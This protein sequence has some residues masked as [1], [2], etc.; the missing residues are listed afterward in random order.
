M[1][2][3]W[4]L[5]ILQRIYRSSALFDWRTRRRHRP[6]PGQWIIRDPWRGKAVE[7]QPLV[8]GKD[9]WEV[10][11]DDWHRF[12]WLRDMRE[13]GGSQARTMSRRVVLEWVER[14][15][16]W[17]ASTW[18]PHVT[19]DRLKNLTLLWGWFGESASL[20]Q[21]HALLTSM[22]VQR[23]CLEKDWAS[24]ATGDE[25]L[26]ALSGLIPATLFLHPGAD[27]SAAAAA[28][29]KE[30]SDLILGDGCHVS[31]RP[32]MHLDLLKALIE[33]R[34]AMAAGRSAG[35]APSPQVDN[36]TSLI[37]D[38]IVRMGSVGRMWRH[39]DGT[40]MG[41]LG[42]SGVDPELAG[43]VLA[44]AGPEGKVTRHAADGGFIRITS[45][46]SVMMMNACPPSF[47]ASKTAEWQRRHDKL[48]ND[49]GALAMEF[50]NGQ[51]LIIVN[52]GPTDAGT[53]PHLRQALASTAAHS[54]LTLDDINAADTEGGDRQ[55][56]GRHTETGPAEGG[57]LAV[58]SHDG[59]EKTHSIIHTRRIFLAT[60]GSDLRGEDELKFTGGPGKTP[61]AA[62]I[63]FHLHPR[64][65]PILSRG[66]KVT[67]RLPG[68]AAPW[69]FRSDGGELD[70][71]DSI[72][73]GRDGAEKTQAVTLTVDTAAIRDEGTISVR[74]G[75]RRQQARRK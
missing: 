19:A 65:T 44:L 13:F 25:R 26:L 14:N 48:S 3:S 60:G 5:P 22:A 54:T 46:R 67:L 69:A 18:Q 31:R 2:R 49:A 39:V 21:Q 51:N 10:H 75:L 58:A 72:F 42:G 23:H 40:F 28:F 11:G 35:A 68:T 71:E 52:A 30:L 70:V 61:A 56:I 15:G 37:E 45:G 20:P 64:V 29:E 12:H 66:G 17:D 24:L 63:R 16:R 8:S 62:V 43:Q 59:Y 50:S 27:I 7:G 41:I 9:P 57:V 38:S 34:A 33:T 32:D 55:A 1:T 4:S 73:M 36:T 6:T 53:K 74:W 47:G